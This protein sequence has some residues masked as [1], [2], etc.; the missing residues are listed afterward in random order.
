MGGRGHTYTYGWFVL[1][2]GR[3][4]HNTVKQLS[5]NCC[6]CLVTNSCPNLCDPIEHST[7]RFLVLHC[8]MEFAQT[9]P[10]SQWCYPTSHVIPFSPW[11]WPFPASESFPIS[12]LF[13]SGDQSVG[14][15]ALASASVFSM[16][17][18]SWFI[19]GWFYLLAV[20]GTLKSPLQHKFESI[21]S[22]A[23]IFCV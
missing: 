9:S 13:P 16:N 18:Q 20:Q 14:A 10:L 22:S 7:P 12:L 4:Q 2:Y 5:S 6:Y 23:L 3:N 1:I 17:I 8:L 11:P 21:A 15:W 19:L